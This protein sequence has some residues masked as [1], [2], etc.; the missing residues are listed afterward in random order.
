MP[1]LPMIYAAVSM[2]CD[3]N[4]SIQ[5]SLWPAARDSRKIVFRVSLSARDNNTVALTEE[6]KS[7]NSSLT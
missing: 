6:S 7:Q 1:F 3:L 2:L 4:S 5:M